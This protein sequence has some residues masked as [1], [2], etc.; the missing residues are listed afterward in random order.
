MT[1]P[2]LGDDLLPAIQRLPVGSGVVFRHYQLEAVAR[3]KL[4]S[5]VRRICAKRGHILMLAGD[6]R[7]ARHWNADG[8]HGRQT[9]PAR[10]RSVPVHNVPEVAEAKRL[11]ADLIFLS[12]LYMTSSHPGSRPL[13]P[14]RFA[15]LARLAFPAKVI[16]LGG[17][18][19]AKAKKWHNNRVHGWAAID[20]FKK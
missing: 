11:R 3:K 16:A 15:Q 13:G 14:V 7:L 10:Y 2:R 19:R 4:Y 12:P 5:E 8:V 17:M 9:G 18:T 6:P 20:A 1:D